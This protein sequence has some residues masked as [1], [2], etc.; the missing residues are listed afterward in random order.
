MKKQG[1]SSKNNSKII[2]ENSFFAVA[3]EVLSPLRERSQHIIKKRFGLVDD[4]SV[5][6]LEN[7]GVDFCVTRERIRQILADA[8][9][10]IRK[11]CAEKDFQ[12]AE[13]KLFLAVEKK[14]GIIKEEDILKELNLH[15]LPSEESAMRFLVNCSQKIQVVFMRGRIE[16]AWVNSDDVLKKVLK[17]LQIAEEILT[18][19]KKLFTD[20]DFSQE[21]LL[22]LPE[23]SK[24]EISNYLNVFSGIKK[25]KFKK[26]GM[27]HWPEVSP[28][29]SRERA[30]LVLKEENRPL[31]FVQIAKLIEKYK[32]STKKAHPQTV[33]NELIKD[34]RFVLIGRGTYALGEWGYTRGVVKDVI[35]GILEKS[36]GPMHKEIIIEKVL[37][38]REVRPATVMINLNSKHFERL[39]NSYQLK[40]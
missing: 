5:Q 26:W 21:I 13:N 17:V 37:L 31:H 8:K 11:K 25:N 10:H 7:I 2:R 23:F 32:I 19:N 15:K 6:M 36:E 29:G 28:K 4:F 34:S 22:C 14:C 12:E 38:V 24:K 30:Y 18:K 27:R 16:K 33:H 1:V 20:D 3:E 35:C 39:G 40:K 9:K